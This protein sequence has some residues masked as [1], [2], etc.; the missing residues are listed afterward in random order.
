M[1]KGGEGACGGCEEGRGGVSEG[2]E[3]II[4]CGD[5]I[6]RAVPPSSKGRRVRVAYTQMSISNA[7]SYVFFSRIFKLYLSPCSTDE[8]LRR[9]VTSCNF[10]AVT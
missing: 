2:V 5:A 4:D 7:L 9:P 8:D 10:I 1:C 6:C 3:G